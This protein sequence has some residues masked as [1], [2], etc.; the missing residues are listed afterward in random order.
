VKTRL[1]GLLLVAATVGASGVE[2]QGPPIADRQS[3]DLAAY[4]SMKRDPAMAGLLSAIVPSLGHAYAGRPVN[5]VIFFIFESAEAA[6]AYFT[7]RA[8]A[9]TMYYDTKAQRD[10]L[11]TVGV[12][13]AVA[14]ALTKMWECAD[15][16]VATDRYNDA[17]R[18]RLGLR[19]G[20]Q[21][22]GRGVGAGLSWRY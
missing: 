11:L 13:C 14:L 17:L 22:P 20:W 10:S 4:Q 6:G 5:G 9:D 12:V 7:L 16:V 8:A 21:G 2:A 3:F 1:L 19:L 18:K 15:A